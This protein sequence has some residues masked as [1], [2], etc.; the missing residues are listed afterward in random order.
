[1][2]V[3]NIT[4]LPLASALVLGGALLTTKDYSANRAEAND[5]RHMVTWDGGSFDEAVWLAVDELAGLEDDLPRRV[6]SFH[7]EILAADE[8]MPMIHLQF[9]RESLTL[10]KAGIITPEYFIREYVEFN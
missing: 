1:M 2:K 7:V 4:I 3:L 5:L 9:N 6:E 10:L 8:A